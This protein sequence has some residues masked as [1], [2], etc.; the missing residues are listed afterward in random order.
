ML[1]VGVKCIPGQPH[2][3]AAVGSADVA[4]AQFSWGFWFLVSEEAQQSGNL[5]CPFALQQTG[6]ITGAAAG[7]RLRIQ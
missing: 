4:T 5:A 3:E 2:P 1:R 7:N 6:E